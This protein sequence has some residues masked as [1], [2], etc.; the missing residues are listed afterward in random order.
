[1]HRSTER[2]RSGAWSTVFLFAG[3]AALL[4]ACSAGQAKREMVGGATVS[5]TQV[6]SADAGPPRVIYVADFTVEP[7]TIEQ[8]Q[9]LVSE[10]TEVMGERPHLLGGGGLL[11]RRMTSDTPT[12]DQV[13]NTLA[14]SIAS[15]L[16]QQNLGFPV[17][18]LAPGTAPPGDGW[19]VNGRFVKV[20]PGN[21]AERAVIG[22]GAGA[23][24]TEVAVEVDRV[25]SGA[26]TP[27][28]R[29]GTNADSGKMPGAAVTMNP[30]AAAAK[31]VLGKNATARD[32]QSMGQEIAKQIGDFARS[33]GAQAN[34]AP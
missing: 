26:M 18:R 2:S 10:A 17:E 6:L 12:A 4:T 7:G 24:V 21:R 32:V 9:G 31:F 27:I 28:L 11:G 25:D 3:L 5:Q 1:M 8:A 15:G 19:L 29:F 34:P 13:V 30:Y 16:S 22:F 33:R 23:A 20:D 14:A